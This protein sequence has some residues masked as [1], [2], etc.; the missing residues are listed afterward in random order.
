[1]K[2]S[3]NIVFKIAFVFVL[4]FISC[5]D[6][7]TKT[8][9]TQLTTDKFFQTETQIEQAVNGAF[10]QFRGIIND[11]WQFNEF[12]TDNATLHF[13]P[14]NRGSGPTLES[15]ETWTYI[16]TTD[17][18]ES[19]YNSH[20]E[21]LININTTLDRMEGA[22][23]DETVARQLESNLKFLRAYYY[24]NLVRYFGEVIIVTEPVE[25]P[26]EAFEFS[27]Q[28]ID[29][30]YALVESDLEDAVDGAVE[31]GE[32]EVGRV[33]KGAALS[34]LGKVYLTRKR[35]SDAI[36]TL[37]Q[38]TLMNYSI[39]PSYADV[40]D[41]NNKNH[42]ES[43][44]DAQYQGGNDLG[45]HSSFIYTFAP[46]LSEGA[47]IDFPGQNGGG[48]NIPTNSIISSYEEG[49]LR[50]AVSLKEGYTNLD[51]DW[52]PVPFINKYNWPHEIRGRT[53]DNWPILRYADVLLML[54]E[55]TN[56]VSGPT[57]EAYGYVNE[58]R[59]RAGLD[60]L[61]GLNKQSFREAVLHERRVELAFENHRWFDLKRTMTDEELADFLN[62]HGQTQITNPQTPRDGIGFGPSD[63]VFQ[64]YQAI[65]PIPQSETLINSNLTQNPGYL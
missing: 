36:N 26:E 53:D 39:L 5:E 65:F 28:P 19:L 33:T 48:W 57:G 31:L 59:S 30:V 40:F 12:T 27:R 13:N 45:L 61:M 14:E 16:P 17:N 54:A 41:P 34:L 37:E 43:I 63:Y 21:A 32:E 60:P 35:Y 3:N 10:A 24:F 51:G 18:I 8:D 1:M 42:A 23:I 4:F 52:V 47:V 6:F 56:E 20:Y 62:A 49:D 46:R 7:I 44:L 58:I 15:L 55:A 25:S 11:Q 2:L 9:P 29:D 38:V 22:N 50:K 64:P